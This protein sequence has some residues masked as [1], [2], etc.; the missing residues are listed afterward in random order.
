MIHRHRIA[1]LALSMLTAL[2]SASPTSAQVGHVYPSERTIVKD[3]VTGNDMIVL[4]NGK[5]SDS[6][7]YQ[8]HP[9]WTSDGKW[10]IFRSDG[11]APVSQVCAVN[12]ASGEIVQVTEG[13]GNN[14]SSLCVARKSM[15]LYFLR[16]ASAAARGLPA[17]LLHAPPP[18]T[19]PTTQHDHPDDEYQV[20]ET[21]LGRLLPDALAGKAGAA[22][23]YERICSTFPHG[24]APGGG[25]ALDAD[26][27]VFYV[28]IHGGDAGQHLPAGVSVWVKPPGARMGTGP[29]GLRKIDIHT[30]K[31]EVVIDTPFQIGHVQS[32]PWVPGEILYCHETGGDA[33]QRMWTTHAD[34]TGNRPLFVEEPLDW[35]T[36]EAVV[37]KD[38]VMF[39]LI[40]HQQRLRTRPTGIC[41]INLRTNVVELLGQVNEHG[42]VRDDLPSQNASGKAED[43]WGGFWHCNGSPDGRWAVGDTFAGNIWLIDRR[44][45]K[46]TLLSTDHKMKP[47][48]AHPT[49]SD[50]SRRILIQSGHFTDGKRL[51]LI[52]LPVPKELE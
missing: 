16:N 39:N 27:N 29:G 34:G 23:S 19:A 26:E 17:E 14:T 25:Q 42:V 30:G 49:F 20:I 10:I 37:T 52:V 48:H 1:L 32:N 4:T 2:T 24:T 13:A 22:S 47:D 44:D 50:D 6:K 9:Q 7:I 3:A 51:Q 41:V 35:V 45:G 33:P 46:R 21:D 43:S 40:G 38:E 11:R 31:M 8:T 5:Q 18:T 28:A 12:E 15:K 36:H